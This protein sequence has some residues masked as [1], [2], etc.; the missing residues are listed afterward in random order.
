MSIDVALAW[1]KAAAGLTEHLTLRGSR[2]WL[3]RAMLADAL[4][5]K[6]AR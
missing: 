3:L 1:R 5:W 4:V 2:I 6:S